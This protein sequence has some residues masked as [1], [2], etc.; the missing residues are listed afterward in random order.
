MSIWAHET[1]SVLRR[2]TVPVPIQIR[3]LMK[4]VGLTSIEFCRNDGRFC[5]LG[6]M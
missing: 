3:G 2:A 4:L 6:I 5:G 1:G